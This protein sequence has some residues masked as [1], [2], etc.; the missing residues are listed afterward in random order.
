MGFTHWNCL[1]FSMFSSSLVR[2][3]FSIDR[4]L[5]AKLSSGRRLFMT[6][7][8]KKIRMQSNKQETNNLQWDSLSNVA[9]KQ[10]K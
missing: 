5:I 2:L 3:R 4:K 6:V 8:K 7:K 1:A 9:W 10:V